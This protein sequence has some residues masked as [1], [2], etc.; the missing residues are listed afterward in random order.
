MDTNTKTN[1]GQ[2]EVYM[3]DD[4]DSLYYEIERR[5]LTLIRDDEKEDYVGSTYTTF[6]QSTPMSVNRQRFILGKQ[7]GSYFCW[8]QDNKNATSSVPVWLLNLW[9]N[10]SNGTGVFIPRVISTRKGNK[11]SRKCKGKG[12]TYKRTID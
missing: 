12:S 5:I 6:K 4:F 10:T 8:T 9:R 7:T 11:P 1:N 2:D 3:G